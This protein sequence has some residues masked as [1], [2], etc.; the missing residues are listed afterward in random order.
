MAVK[1][2]ERARLAAK[3][4]V[5]VLVC[6]ETGTGKEVLARFLHSY[7]NRQNEPFVAVNCAA[8]PD[9]LLEGELFGHE[10]GSFSGACYM[11]RG[12]L[13]L[14]GKG[15]L[16]LDEIGELDIRLQAKLLRAL[17]EREYSR[18][19]GQRPLRVDT[20]VISTTNKELIHEIHGGRFRLDLYHRISATILNLPTLRD[21]PADIMP[22]SQHFVAM[23]ANDRHGP[24]C[25]HKSAQRKL[26]D[27]VWLGNVRELAN[28]I[29]RAVIFSRENYISADLL[30]L[31]L[32]AASSAAH[33]IECDRPEL[34]RRTTTLQQ[35]IKTL[36]IEALRETS[37]NRAKAA[38]RLGISTKTL[39]RRMHRC[40]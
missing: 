37:G 33:M 2:L 9:G 40:G 35:H 36:I 29:H 30:E 6:G 38:A 24:I 8:I 16:L 39:N 3:H 11:Q 27:H 5:S 26:L 25:V 28:I 19:G 14:A 4:S 13:E 31:P 7:S 21:R 10:R 22:L 17:Q 20:Q 34:I 32:R 18:L 1:T 15:T 23:Y 12:K